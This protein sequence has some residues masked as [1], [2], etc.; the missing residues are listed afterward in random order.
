[1][2]AHCAIKSSCLSALLLTA[3]TMITPA[4]A[5]NV[6]DAVY[7]AQIK[8]IQTPNHSYQANTM[9]GKSV[10]GEGVFAGGVEYVKSN[11][12]WKRSPITQQDML[13]IGQEKLKTH[14]E[15][16]TVVGDQ[17]KDGQ[18]VTMYKLHNTELGVD[19]QVWIAK[20]SGLRVHETVLFD[21]QNST[22]IRYDYSN[23]QP[24]AGVQ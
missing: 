21:S 4:H 19:A 17:N 6:C 2:L 11:G 12:Q 18:A 9:A 24:P 3:A 5:A 10:V 13:E 8:S 15:T 14:P 16:C 20:S 7:Q 23:V 22:D 1:M